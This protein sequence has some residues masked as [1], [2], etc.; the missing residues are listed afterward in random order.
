MCSA[1]WSA[2]LAQRATEP[3]EVTSCNKIAERCFMLHPVSRV[4]STPA[5]GCWRRACSTLLA[6]SVK[7]YRCDPTTLFC[8]RLLGWGL[9]FSVAMSALATVLLRTRRHVVLFDRRQHSQWP[10]KLEDEPDTPLACFQAAV[11][12]SQQRSP[13]GARVFATAVDASDD[14]CADIVAATPAGGHVA[15]VFPNAVLVRSASLPLD[16]FMDALTSETAIASTPDITVT[17]LRELWLMVCAHS[18][19]YI[20][21]TARNAF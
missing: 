3:S 17:P 14:A 2:S 10:A 4:V 9:A 6:G 13:D 19:R 21:R 5:R 15:A 20:G 8:R 1:S 11:K 7:P 12:A 16:A 18:K